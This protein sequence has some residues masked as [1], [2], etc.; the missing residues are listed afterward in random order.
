MNINGRG[1]CCEEES[2][3]C[4]EETQEETCCCESEERCCCEESQ[5]ETCCCE[6]EESCCC[7]EAQEEACCCES[8]ESCCCE[9]EESCCCEDDINHQQFRLTIPRILKDIE[10]QT[11]GLIKVEHFKGGGAENP[12][13]SFHAAYRMHGDSLKVLPQK[14]SSCCCGIKS[15]EAMDF[16]SQQWGN[17]IELHDEIENVESSS[18]DLFLKQAV[19][20]TFTISGMLFQDAWNLDFKRLQRCYICEADTERGMIPF[21]AY[22][23]TDIHGKALYRK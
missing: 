12:Y 9:S 8:E 3:C 19:E 11:N 20:E 21:C 6:S 23:L 2:S 5:E 10:E 16:V 22:N 15:E 13:C 1:E 7:E 17:N 4:C 14:Q 18:L